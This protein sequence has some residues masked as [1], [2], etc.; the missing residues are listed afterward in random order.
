MGSAQARNSH[1]KK[2]QWGAFIVIF[3]FLIFLNLRLRCL[4]TSDALST[5]NAAN[6][7]STG[8]F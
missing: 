8:T 1:N 4:H 7:T 5:I 3:F 6:M 2:V